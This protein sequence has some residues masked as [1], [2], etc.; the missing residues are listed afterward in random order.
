MHHL[1]I[2]SEAKQSHSGHREHVLGEPQSGLE[3]HHEASRRSR[4]DLIE[5]HGIATL[6][7]D[8]LLGHSAGPVPRRTK[9]PGFAQA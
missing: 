4:G 2:A 5:F 7:H 1:V 6:A 9:N 8:D 3:R